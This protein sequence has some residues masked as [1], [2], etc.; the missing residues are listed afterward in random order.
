MKTLLIQ[1]NQGIEIRSDQASVSNPTRYD[2]IAARA[3][4]GLVKKPKTMDEI[5]A[6][7]EERCKQQRVLIDAY[8][9]A[10]PLTGTNT[11]F[12]EL[13]QQHPDVF[14]DPDLIPPED[15]I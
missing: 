1:G 3:A 11:M 15:D 8:K 13:T 10:H 9:A 7:A 12:Q 2:I 6:D 5:N 14:N 4:L